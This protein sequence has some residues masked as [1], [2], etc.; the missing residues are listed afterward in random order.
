MFTP[1]AGLGQIR[2]K[3]NATIQFERQSG[4]TVDENGFAVVITETVK[5]RARIHN[6]DGVTNNDN[7]WAGIDTPGEKLWGRLSYPLKFPED[8]NDL[9]EVNLIFDDGRKGFARIKVKTQNPITNGQVIGQ[10]FNAFFKA[11]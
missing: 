7:Y 3:V 4:V 11:E 6:D 5:L 10:Y 8:F 1:D 9:S 2:S